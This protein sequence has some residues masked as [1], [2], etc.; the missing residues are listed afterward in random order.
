M[1]RKQEKLRHLRFPNIK[2][3]CEVPLLIRSKY[4]ANPSEVLGLN[5]RVG[6]QLSQLLLAGHSDVSM[7]Y[8]GAQSPIYIAPPHK[9]RL[10]KILLWGMCS[11]KVCFRCGHQ[12]D[13]RV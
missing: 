2:S 9:D 7:D 3:L 10:I 12:I 4:K 6:S 1:Q 13:T 5:M 8:T 11:S